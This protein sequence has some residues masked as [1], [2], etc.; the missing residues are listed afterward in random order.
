[1]PFGALVVWFLM[2]VVDHLVLAA[3]MGCKCVATA[4]RIYEMARWDRGSGDDHTLACSRRFH[5]WLAADGLVFGAL[6]TVMLPQGDAV[7]GATM[8]ATVIAIGA[9]GLVVLAQ[10]FAAMA[11]LVLPMLVPAMLWQFMLGDRLAIYNG[12][13]MAIFLLLVIFEGK[14]AAGFTTEMLT[15]RFRFADLAAQREQALDLA[16]RNS[17]VKDRFLATMSHEM[18]TPLHGMLGLARLAR[19]E[20]GADSA[21]G[22][23]LAMVA[24]TGEH[25]QSLIDDMLELAR[26]QAGRSSL[27]MRPFDLFALLRSVVQMTQAS[28][29]EKGLALRLELPAEATAPV[30]ADERRLRQILLNLLCNSI[31]FTEQ[32]GVTLRANART[33]GGF[34]IEVEDSGPGVPIDQVQA[35]FDAF[36]QLDDG[37][38]RRHGGAG[39]GLSISRELAR[40]MGGELVCAERAPPGALF[41]LELPLAAAAPAAPPS[42]AAVVTP[43][44]A[45]VPLPPARLAGSVL[46]VEDNPVN[47][48]VAQATLELL[49]LTVHTATDGAEGVAEARALRPDLILMDC[50]MPGIDGFEATR[51]IRAIEIEQGWPRSPIVALTANAMEGD[52][53]RSLQA[54][55]DDHLPKPFRDEDLHAALARWLPAQRSL[56]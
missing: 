16:E 1:V 14:R 30:Q 20:A 56:G 10:S 8:I 54:G 29:A 18:R 45:G 46:V 12:G 24:R 41:R 44:D 25:L 21:I 7:F 38:G 36:H 26:L 47:L 11:A 28:A 19:H 9:V 48:I 31:K 49:G 2:P 34:S 51:R 13:G 6:G 55:M 17:A 32:G 5:A 35:I 39:L 33:G 40:A 22:E 42:A 53:E 52:R 50:Q 3:W 15:L 43:P 4:G 23:R 27:D 37:F